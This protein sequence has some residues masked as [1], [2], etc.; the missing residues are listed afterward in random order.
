VALPF[1]TRALDPAQSVPK[2]PTHALCI[3]GA[4]ES[5]D[6]TGLADL[7]FRLWEVEHLTSS[8][9]VKTL[10]GID[11]PRALQDLEK[12]FQT[13]NTSDPYGQLPRL[14]TLVR[15]EHP[16]PAQVLGQAIPFAKGEHL[17]PVAVALREMN[18]PDVM[19]ALFKRLE[20]AKKNSRGVWCS[21]EGAYEPALYT[22]L[23]L[24]LDENQK[25]RVAN[26]ILK[27]GA[28][29]RAGWTG[30]KAVF[31]MQEKWFRELIVKHGLQKK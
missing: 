30:D 31:A 14:I 15:Q 10:L 16:A 12:S 8:K 29:R 13:I 25:T 26:W 22:L 3:G 5:T 23:K 20:M 21:D 6:L 18:D 1:F 2:R 17:A 27:R 9:L 24:P 28:E 11:R 7:A 4:L 19:P